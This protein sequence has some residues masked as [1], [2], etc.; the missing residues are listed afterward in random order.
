MT[1]EPPT[2]IRLHAPPLVFLP[3]AFLLGPMCALALAPTS[4]S[5]APAAAATAAMTMDQAVKMAEKRFHARVVKA[6]T[7]KEA[8]STT[9]VLRLLNDTGHVWTVK[10]DAAN[11]SVK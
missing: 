3:L 7:Q 11:G 1:D 8:G 2:M 9:Y 4:A 6:E 5:A 10:V